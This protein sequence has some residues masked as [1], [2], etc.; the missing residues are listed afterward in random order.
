MR[1][2][3]KAAQNSLFRSAASLG[4]VAIIGTALL[5]GVD[6]LTAGRIAEQEK[7][8]ILEQL[9]QIIPGNHDNLLLDDRFSFKDEQHFPN[10]QTVTVYRARLQE[11]PIAVV[12]KFKA[13]SGY[14]GDIHLLAGINAEGN[15]RGVRVTSHRETPG[16]GDG[17][18][19]EK[20]DWVTGF[21]GKSLDN[22]QRDKWAV[23]RDGG[24]FDQFTGA[25]IPP[26]AVVAAVQKALN[27][28]EENR[29][30]LF[31]TPS[32]FSGNE[33]L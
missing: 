1:P 26:R 29:E 8:V 6:R 4:L 25:T 27:Y 21:N 28:F 22:P 17:I 16:L 12:L 30:K 5:T 23:R 33:A 9:G 18:E 32:E 24:E 2:E 11:K 15:L 7:R 14:N 20:S 19:L 3:M 10:G 31:D 13:V